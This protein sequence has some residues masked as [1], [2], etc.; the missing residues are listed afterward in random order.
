MSVKTDLQ[1]LVECLKYRQD[2]PERER[3]TLLTI[4]SLCSGSSEAQDFLR[5]CGGLTYIV[6]ILSAAEDNDIK[7]AT[8][9]TLGCAIERNVFSQ[10]RLCSEAMFKFLYCQL[11]S[12]KATVKLRR[13]SI[14]LLMCLVTNN[15]KGQA[16]VRT[17]HCLDSLLQLFRNF[18]GLQ[19]PFNQPLK[20]DGDDSLELWKD[21]ASTLCGCVNNPQNDENQ[22]ECASSIPATLYIMSHTQH[23]SVLQLL[24]SFMSLLTANNAVNQDR[25]HM[26]GG[27]DVSVNKLTSVIAEM[28]ADLNKESIQSASSL[29]CMLNSATADNDSNLQALSKLKVVPLLLQLLALD[30]INQDLKLKVILTLGCLVATNEESQREV[31]ENKGLRLLLNTMMTSQEEECIKTATLVLHS[32]VNDVNALEL[33]KTLSETNDGR[34]DK[35]EECYEEDVKPVRQTE[36]SGTATACSILEEK[37]ASLQEELLQERQTRRRLEDE[38]ASLQISVENQES[39]DDASDQKLH[40]E[41]NGEDAVTQTKES[42]ALKVCL[43]PDETDNQGNQSLS[44]LQERMK[45]LEQKI[46][47]LTGVTSEVEINRNDGAAN[48][49]DSSVTVSDS[50][51]GREEPSNSDAATLKTNV[52]YCPKKLKVVTGDTR[53]RS[54]P[55]Q[56]QPVQEKTESL[57]FKVPPRPLTRCRPLQLVHGYVNVG[58]SSEKEQVLQGRK[59]ESQHDST[60]DAVKHT[61]HSCMNQEN[62]PFLPINSAERVKINL[63]NKVQESDFV[64]SQ[65]NP[66]HQ[67]QFVT[68]SNA[69]TARVGVEQ[70]SSYHSQVAENQDGNNSSDTLSIADSAVSR[71]DVH[72][73][74][75]AKH[76]SRCQQSSISTSKTTGHENDSNDITQRTNTQFSAAENHLFI[77][78][79]Q[80]NDSEEVVECLPANATDVSCRDTATLEFKQKIEA[81]PKKTTQRTAA[82]EI[83]AEME[84]KLR[85]IPKVILKKTPLKVKNLKMFTYTYDEHH[86]LDDSETTVNK[87]EQASPEPGHDRQLAMSC[88]PG[89]KCTS[90][91]HIKSKKCYTVR[92]VHGKIRCSKLYGSRAFRSGSS[93][94]RSS[95]P[96]KELRTWLQFQSSFLC[97]GCTPP[98]SSPLLDS[99][100]LMPCL[101]T[102]QAALCKNHR[103]LEQ[104]ITQY[105]ARKKNELGLL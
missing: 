76:S 29:I 84:A 66:V 47:S 78:T 62:H 68:K 80:P 72:L 7:V 93:L 94:C 41:A 9:Y 82:G 5:T 6:N 81:K 103:R 65:F 40:V 102:N 70:S 38:N 104:A 60:K 48:K 77:V 31:V 44:L 14:F 55:K 105:V 96:S 12:V 83:D 49:S 18:P 99:H 64:K 32:C 90:S 100:T 56:A 42:T 33:E 30:V 54:L 87:N 86:N 22:I 11:S 23:S 25:F 61:K 27:L 75:P 98:R 71:L 2:D 34:L 85:L 97:P 59:R 16:F 43:E 101:K 74:H 73:S 4:A 50:E 37:I 91:K 1:C 58:D 89:N 52:R 57:N 39:S 79:G 20:C 69:L 45:V 3:D 92:Y 8:L 10:S 21:V 63:Y 17:T 46:K 67:R 53:D 95:C 24:C 15:G 26:L 36:K 51:S 88:S 35:D 19:L 13:S 28:K